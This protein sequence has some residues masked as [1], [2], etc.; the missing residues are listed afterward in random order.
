M[1]KL[2]PGVPGR[3]SNLKPLDLVATTAHELKTPLVL[4]SGL[5]EMLD[6][7][8]FGKLNKD[9]IRY[10]GKIASASERLL[11][12]VDNLLTINRSEHGRL[13][14]QF[15]P[16]S[17][18]TVMRRVL[19][20]LAP[21]IAEQEMTIIWAPNLKLPPVRAD[22]GSL[23]QVLFNLLDNTLKYS[24]PGSTVTLR[25]KRA[26][27]RLVVQIRDQGFGIK[28]SDLSKLFERFGVVNQ[29]ISANASSSGLGLFIVKNL[30]QLQGGEIS[31]KRLRRGTCF[32]LSLPAVDQM[33]LFGGQT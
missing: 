21:R 29:P 24:P 5:A 7:G 18:T 14:L 4:I 6:K 25:F 20:E 22:N 26:P 3:K 33:E 15:E 13:M 27:G 11:Q 16:I 30:V 32:T 10:I 8:D 23:Y 12:M 2:N 28:S 17:V 19:E 31:V 1:A 9:Q